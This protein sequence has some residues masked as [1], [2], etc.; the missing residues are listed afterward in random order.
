M[1]KYNS[2]FSAPDTEF[3]TSIIN[4]GLSGSI[5]VH[6]FSLLAMLLLEKLGFQIHKEALFVLMSPLY[7]GQL[8]GLCSE[9]NVS[10]RS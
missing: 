2:I 5:I 1:K 6:P 7:P 8:M 10:F 4:W 3:V 9:L